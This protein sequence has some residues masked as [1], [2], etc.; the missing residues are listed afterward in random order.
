MKLAVTVL[1]DSGID[2]SR[3]L[4]SVT[5]LGI[6]WE[7]VALRHSQDADVIAASLSDADYVIAGSERYDAQ[8]M[9]T[10]PMLKLIVR[11]GVGYDNVDLDAAA[12]LGIA[13]CN[14]PGSNAY[15]VAE[16]VLAMMLC[17]TRHIPA[18][19]ARIKEGRYG[20]YIADSMTGR[21]GLV[22][23]GA[24]ARQ[25]A[26]LLKAF[27]VE[28]YAYDPF[29]SAEEMAKH[30]V[31]KAELDELVAKSDILSLHLPATKENRRMV[32][33]RF[34][35]KMKDGAYFFNAARGSLVD[36][37]ALAEALLSGKL[38]GA[39]LD[40]F[41]PEP[42]RAD[43]RLTEVENILL[44]PHASTANYS[45][46]HK[47]LEAGARAAADFHTGKEPF[48]LLNPQYAKNAR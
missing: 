47:V 43:S 40:V 38:A 46:F 42:L 41:D 11:N 26:R 29:V 16:H 27:D 14:L 32:D 48:H 34:I 45:C 31:K 30:C 6:E 28:V 44:S 19:T 12:K 10:L 1:D 5:E 13:V 17:V 25:L 2:I 37:D 3:D 24:I 36:E 9:A 18:H 22:G 23:F 35:G 4:R 39:G 20:G 15:S 7:G 21:V 33:A 8:T